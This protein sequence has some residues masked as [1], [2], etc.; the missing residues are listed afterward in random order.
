[1]SMAPGDYPVRLEVDPDLGDRNRLTVG[2]RAV[3]AIP[4]TILVGWFG[5]G[6]S[7]FTFGWGRDGDDTPGGP[8]GF[9]GNGILWAAAGVAAI[10]AWF[11]IVFTGNH[12]RGLF[13]F[14]MFVFRWRV[15][16]SAYGALFRDEYPP[17]GDGDG[18]YQAR[19]LV[20]YPEEP[21]NRLSVGLRFIY[22]IPHLFIL[23]FLGFAWAITSII[24]W[25]AILFT[26]RYPQGLAEF[27]LGVFRWTVRVEAYMFL[28]RD[29]YPPFSL[30]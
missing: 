20:D 8:F 14:E 11:A 4:H 2:F 6:Y 10:I 5:L 30:S 9:V 12:P 28:L 26:G 25:F 24:A 22:A 3:L 13:D 27:G 7:A 29:E 19:V 21:R 18:S 17:F 1:M 23:A 15:R 16:A